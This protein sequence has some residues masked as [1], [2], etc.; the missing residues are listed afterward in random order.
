MKHILVDP[1]TFDCRNFGDVAMLQVAVARLRG[2]WPD[3]EI[4]VL[5]ADP[6]ALERFVPGAVPVLNQTRQLWFT[7]HYLLGGLHDRMPAAM[8]RGLVRWK[9]AAQRRAPAFVS[10]AMSLKLRAQG[11]TVAAPAA[12]L[13]AMDRADLLVVSGAA[14][15]AD[16]ARAHAL[17]V[18]NTLRLAAERGVPAV[19]FG[20][21]IGP[22]D[23]PELRERARAVFPSLRQI[24]LREE[25]LGRSL[26]AALGVSDD[27]VI[28]TGDDA[29]EMAY[30]ARRDRL[31]DAVGVNVRLAEH[32]GLDAAFSEALRDAIQPF[33]RA[34]DAALV[35]VPIAF[36]RFADDPTAIRRVLAGVDDRSD[37]GAALAGPRDVVLQVGRC[38]VLVTGAYHAAVFAL[39]QGVPAVCLARVPYYV[40]K[41]LG[42]AEQFGDG[43]TVVRLDRGAS[44]ADVIA[45]LETA[46]SRAVTVRAGLLAAAERLRAA[47]RAAAATLPSL[48]TSAVPA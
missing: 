38:R 46:W 15:F 5:T 35:P 23:N 2:L 32:S 7:E 39:A 36:H 18:L 44:A 19:M 26:L 25:R 42:L 6:V 22:M 3:A 12:F 31:G 17:L 40:A 30:D 1:S 48:L 20:Q 33:A 37:G 21:G 24:A 10:G 34:R 45:A 41:F 28:F 4:A 13:A 43:C 14:T 11:R 9:H 47:G 8:S 29:V 27:R 16:D